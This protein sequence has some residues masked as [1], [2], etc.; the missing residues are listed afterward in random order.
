[1]K[2]FRFIESQGLLIHSEFHQLL[3]AQGLD[4]FQSLYGY[5]G[6]EIFKENRFR[7]VIR[8]SLGG[9]DARP[10]V[11]HLKK[12]HPPFGDKLKALFTGF[13]IGEGAENEWDKILKLHAI[14]IETMVPVAFG[15]VRKWGLPYRALTLTEHLYGAEK[16]ETYLPTHFEQ[17]LGD[18]K[19]IWSKRAIIRA[20]AGL[21]RKLHAARLHHQDFYLGHIL[22]APRP[23][24]RFTLYLIDL[25]RVKSPKRL[26]TS[27]IVKD[28]A[29][30][31]FSAAETDCLTRTDRLRFMKTYLE[32]ERLTEADLALIRKIEDKSGRIAKHHAK[33]L[34]R[35]ASLGVDTPASPEKDSRSKIK[36]RL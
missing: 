8:I 28:L 32:K 22:I 25:Q 2:Q 20:V 5:T 12:H 23:E 1:V 35:R 29:Q 3:K 15:S 21:A 11:F 34:A 19:L 10:Q 26:R 17:G 30:I 16:L 13:S 4:S 33:V 9:K 27:R 36:S 31:Y 7:S 18:P 14:G 6:G 24:G